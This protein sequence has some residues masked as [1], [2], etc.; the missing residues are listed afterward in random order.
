MQLSSERRGRWCANLLLDGVGYDLAGDR[1]VNGVFRVIEN[2]EHVLLTFD[3]LEILLGLFRVLVL[4][5]FG[6]FEFV[7]NFGFRASNLVAAM[8][9][10]ELCGL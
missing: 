3:F 8:L 1:D 9:R 4:N 2:C 5:L 10:C 7:S 6:S